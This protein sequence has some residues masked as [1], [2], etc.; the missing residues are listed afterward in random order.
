MIR[1]ADTLSL[2][3]LLV[4]ASPLAADGPTT[5]PATEAP[6]R[7]VERL[8][9]VDRAIEH[10]GGALY[11]HSATSLGVCSKSGC[12]DLWVKVDGDRTEYEVTGK[13]RAGERRVRAT[14]ERVEH[15]IDGEM[16]PV[17]PG[18][19]QVLRD[20]AMARIYFPF[21]PYRL[22][23]PSVF[24]QALGSETWDGRALDKVKVTFAAGS[25]TDADDQYMYWFDPE[26]GRVEML[27]YSFHTGDG[28]L[29]FRRATNHRRV[30]GILFFDQ[31]NLGA[32]GPGLSVD[33]I[34]PAFVAERMR[35]ISTV[36]LEN[37]RVEPLA[38]D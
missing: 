30:G 24:K 31:E 35:P 34:D 6:S 32:D 10:H 13:V 16:V 5:A 7:G 28:G 22:N 3:L 17:E 4:F 33:Q 14:P 37:I 27:A 38:G 9:I 18:G 23:D 20:W 12:F 25:S 21:L 11:R 8:E 26:T 15:W 29:R 19:E 1:T 36:R 2:V